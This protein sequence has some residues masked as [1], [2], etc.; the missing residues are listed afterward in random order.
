M[1]NFKDAEQAAF[2]EWLDRKRPSGEVESVQSQ[3]EHSYEYADLCAEYQNDIQAAA[4]GLTQ[5]ALEY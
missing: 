1:D 3:W 5:T 4:G 2:E